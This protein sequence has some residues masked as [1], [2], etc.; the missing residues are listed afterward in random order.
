[1]THINIDVNTQVFNKNKKLKT[2]AKRQKQKQQQ[3]LIVIC[4]ADFWPDSKGWPIGA[5]VGQSFGTSIGQ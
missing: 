2:T 3:G 1:M 4:F 5:F